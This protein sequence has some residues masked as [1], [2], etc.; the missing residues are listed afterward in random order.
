MTDARKP[1]FDGLRATLNRALTNNDVIAGHGFLNT[2]GAPKANERFLSDAGL[3]HIKRSEGLRIKAYPDPASG[4][5][6]WTIGYGSTGP[7]V[8]PGL[9]ITEAQAEERLRRDV[10]R[11]EDAV[12]RLAPSTTQ[13]QFDALVSFAFNLGAGNLE[14]STLLRKHNAGDFA[15]AA[16]EFGKWTLAAGKQMPGLVRRRADEAAIYRGK[17]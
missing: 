2:L 11:F 16:D 10:V 3:D 7:D 4:G 15:G 8:K 14:K 12:R 1:F 5:D 6:P 13:G 17:A 9:V